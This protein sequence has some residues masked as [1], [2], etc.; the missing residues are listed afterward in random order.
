MSNATGRGSGG[1]KATHS[2][3]D[4]QNRST[5]WAA[6]MVL[7]EKDAAL[8]LELPAGVTLDSIRCETDQPVDDTLVLTSAGG[9]LFIQVKHSLSLETTADSEFGS[10]IDQ[11]VRQFLS[12]RNSAANILPS[13]RMLDANLDRFL[14]LVSSRSSAPVRVDLP[15]FLRRLRGLAP[16][17]NGMALDSATHNEPERRAHTVVRGHIVRAWQSE[18]GGDPTDADIGV[19]LELIH[20]LVLDL[21]PG[22]THDRE[23][24]QVLRSSVVKEA[25]QADSAWD[26]LIEKCAL[27]AKT[28][29]GI[30]RRGLQGILIDKGFE[31]KGAR[32]FR[33]DIERLRSHSR[34]TSSRFT[35]Q[36]TID[37]GSTKVKIARPCTIALGA[38]APAGSLLVVG[39]PGSGKTVSLYQTVELLGRNGHDVVYLAADSLVAESLGTL[40]TELNLEHEFLEVLENWPGTQSGFLV[41]DALDAARSDGSAKTLRELIDAAIRSG[42]RWRV[43]ASIRE[44]DLRYSAQLQTLFRGSPI[45][46]LSHPQFGSVRHV[47]V[48]RLEPGELDQ[49]RSQAPNLGEFFDGADVKLREL[50]RVAFNLRLMGELLGE[51][52]SAEELTPIET[53]LELL[54]RYWLHR[55]ISSDHLGDSREA[56]LRL[57]SEGMVAGRSLRTSRSFVAGDPAAGNPLGQVLRSGVL[58]EWQTPGRSRP[59]RDFLAYSHHVLHDY[60]IARLLLRGDVTEL[61]K[62]LGEAPDL[63]MAIRPSL[64]MHYQHLWPLDTDHREFWTVTKAVQLGPGIPEIAKTVG[65]AVAAEFFEASEDCNPVLDDLGVARGS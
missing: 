24:R 18:T 36:S 12:V 32:S 15:E 33:A 34:A 48:P 22:E 44:F 46:G 51:G 58:V 3:T 10:V 19:V 63:A 39:E 21:D 20:V 30:D 13:G 59:D 8:P 56:V 49:V 42:G 7:A 25:A 14:I 54:D 27:L 9:I 45:A 53:Q 5:S 57:A 1:G 11:F 65:P 6:V 17:R 62:L 40:R 38:G 61:V 26:T 31:L 50:L 2:G 23:A 29:S 60:A 4:H 35:Q 41:I 43:I 52:V 47:L 55:V 37:V 64:V 16:Y 28:Q